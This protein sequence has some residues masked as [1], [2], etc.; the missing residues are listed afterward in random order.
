[1]EQGAVAAENVLAHAD[2]DS[3]E[4]YENVHHHV[5][6]A[7]LGVYP[8]ARVGHSVASAEAAGI[9]HVAATREAADDGVF[10]TKDVPRGLA[11]LVVDADDGTV[12]GYQGLHYHAD[13]MAKTMQVAVEMGLDVRALPDRAYHPTLPEIIDGLVRETAAEL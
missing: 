11:R 13:T 3:L 5:V 2:G 10:R 1:K 4:L 7:G 6:F 9:E 12:L 8:Y